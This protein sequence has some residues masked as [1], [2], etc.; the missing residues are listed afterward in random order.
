MLL[1][2]SSQ[3]EQIGLLDAKNHIKILD[4]YAKLEADASLCE[5]SYTKLQDIRKIIDEI[6]KAE[7]RASIDL[8]YLE[9]TIQ[10]LQDMIFKINKG[11]PLYRH[12]KS[13]LEE[14]VRQKIE[15]EYPNWEKLREISVQSSEP[16]RKQAIELGKEDEKEKNRVWTAKAATSPASSGDVAANG[17]K[18]KSKRKSSFFGLFKKK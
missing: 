9:T 12:R 10:L 5:K 17:K 18:E 15:G 3:N 14:I 2:I 4:K 16:T 7:E 8:E 13:I 1:E 11:K 6:K